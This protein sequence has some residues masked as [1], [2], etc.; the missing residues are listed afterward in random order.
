MQSRFLWIMGVLI[1]ATAC[2]SPGLYIPEGD[3][4]AGRE[5]FAT[6]E[7][8]SCHRVLAENFP[9]PIADPPVPVVLGSP[10]DKKSRTYLAESILASSHSFAKPRE[11]II[12]LVILQPTYE[13]IGEGGES[14]MGDYKDAMT[15]KQ[16]VDLVAYL[17]ALQNRTRE[18]VSR[19]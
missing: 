17:D 15:V 13:D 2:D 4:E 5:V 18:E 8:H 9:A 10:M 7:C 11:E 6:L 14:R 19:N 3:A 16:W 12:G 1:L